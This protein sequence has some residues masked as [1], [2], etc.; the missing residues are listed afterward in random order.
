MG[1][2]LRHQAVGKLTT[3]TDEGQSLPGDTQTQNNIS[4]PTPSPNLNFTSAYS[5]DDPE[6][7]NPP[8]SKPNLQDPATNNQTNSQPTNPIPEPLAATNPMDTTPEAQ[9]KYRAQILT[10]IAGTTIPTLCDTGCQRSCISENFLRSHPA[11]YQC[12][13]KPYTGRTV[14]IDG[15]RV[16]TIGIINAEFRI[17]GRRLR[18]NL[19]IVR[20][21][22]FDFVLGWDFFTKYN[23][24]IH[25][26]KGYFTFEN[27]KVD[28]IPNT[29]QLSSTH[30]SLAEDAVIPPLSKMHTEA[31][32]YINPADNITTTDTVEVEP[33]RGNASRVAVAKTVSKV[34]DGRFMVELLNPYDT[35][36]KIEA[37]S[38][39][40]H[41]VFTSDE[42]LAGLAE[43]TGITFCFNGDESYKMTEKASAAADKPSGGPASTSYATPKKPPEAKPPDKASELTTSPSI[44]YSS[45]AEDAKPHLKDLKHLLEVKHG[46]IF[47]TNDRDR[48]CTDLVSH[49]ANI[50]PGP[51]IN[52]PPYRTTPEMQKEM[53]RQV[54]EM[55]ADGL[56]SHSTS[57]YSAPVLLV[58]KKLGGWRFCTD[59][60]KVNARCERMVYPLPRI[61]DALRRLKNPRYFSTMDLQKG[62]WQVPIE[63]SD[64]KYFAFST[65]TMHVEYNCMPMGALNS[66]ATMQALMSLILRG[67]PME[68]VICFLDDILVASSSMEEHIH[69]LDLVL[70]AITK[71]KLKLNPKKCL[72]A[73]ESVSCLGH[74]LS[75]DG[76]GPDPHNLDKIRKWKP[77][78]NVTE[79][80]SFL[81]LTGYYRQ[82]IKNYARVAAPLSDLTKDGVEWNWTDKAQ[83][84]FIHLRDYLTSNSI[85][86]YP[87]FSKPFW[88]KSDASGCSVGF[89]LTQFFDG[90]ERVIAYGSKKLT[91]TQKNYSTYDR[92][93][94]GILTAIRAYSH[95][96]RHS[97][98]KVVTDHRPL[99]NLRT[100]DPKTDATGRRVRWSIEL[101]LFDFEVIY[102]KGRQHS[103]ADAMS[104]ITDHDDYA[105]E[106]EYAGLVDNDAPEE[107]EYALL[108]A[109]DKDTSTAVDLVSDDAKRAL[110]AEAQNED[111]TI[112]E[113]KEILRNK[114]STAPSAVPFY[115]QNF[116]RLILK[117]GILYRRAITGSADLPILQAI[118]PPKLI[119]AVLRD[120]HGSIFAG[121]PGHQRFVSILQ[122]HVTWPG[123]YKDTKNFVLKCPE[124]DLVTE[125]N[126][127]P[128][129]EL[130]PMNPEYVFQ[131]VCCDLIALPPVP[132]GWKYVCVFMDVFSRHVMFYKLKNK[133][134]ESFARALEDYVTHVGCPQ[135][136]TC[137]NGSEF[138]SEL[139][140]AV[141]KVLGIKKK[142]SVV[143][144]PQSQGMVERM[145]RSI[146]AQLTK[147][148][149]QFGGYWPEHLHYVA[150]AHNAA[151]ASRTGESPNLV[152]FG[153]ELPLPTFTSNSV[154]TLRS[155]SVS[156]YVER[157]KQKVAVVQE[158]VKAEAIR[159]SE[160]TAEL[161]NKKVKHQPYKEGDYVYYKQIP[162]NRTKIDPRWLGPVCVT[163]RHTSATGTPG[164]TYT[165][166][167]KGG[168]TLRR[169]YE[170]LKAV[171]ADVT[172]P[173]AVEDLP[174]APAPRIPLVIIQHSEDEETADTQN[175]PVATRTRSRRAKAVSTANVAATPATPATSLHQAP[176]AIVST[177]QQLTPMT[178][179]S[180]PNPITRASTISNAP[181]PVVAP[182][183][184]TGPTPAPM[185]PTAPPTPSNT[186]TPASVAPM[187]LPA[188]VS[189]P[190]S[191]GVQI[192]VVSAPPQQPN[193]APPPRLSAGQDLNTTVYPR[194]PCSS[195][196]DTDGEVVNSSE[197]D[198]L[199]QNL[200]DD[201]SG[202]NSFFWE[203]DIEDPIL[204]PDAQEGPS[205]VPGRD[206]YALLHDRHPRSP[207][208]GG[209]T[210]EPLQETMVHAR[211]PIYTIVEE[212]EPPDSPPAIEAVEDRLNASDVASQAAEED[213][214]AVPM[215]AAADV[216]PI[217][218]APDILQIQLG[219][220]RTTQQQLNNANSDEPL[221][222]DGLG[223][224][225]V[226]AEDLL[227]IPV[228]QLTS[229]A[230]SSGSSSGSLN[231][232]KHFL[233]TVAEEMELRE[234]VGPKS[235]DVL[236]YKEYDLRLASRDDRNKARQTWIC[237]HTRKY[238]NCRGR[239]KLEVHDLVNITPGAIVIDYTPHNHKPK[240]MESHG[241]AAERT[242]PDT[243]TDLDG[244]ASFDNA[245]PSLHAISRL[246]ER[247]FEDDFADANIKAKRHSSPFTSME[248]PDDQEA[249]PS[250]VLRPPDVGEN[251][252]LDL[253]TVMVD[254]S[255]VD[256]WGYT[257]QRYVTRPRAAADIPG[258]P[259]TTLP[260]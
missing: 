206:Y 143:Y 214:M 232:F 134:T 119:Q 55:L 53:D 37:N 72:F 117:D 251:P 163:K 22:V 142:T 193:L 156:E 182:T 211:S 198:L 63:P 111:D 203:N 3:G 250:S 87:D 172:E 57:P 139:V 169:N 113:I 202:D 176:T 39:L 208:S 239:L 86:S 252:T 42:E 15:S 65:G 66:S 257:I 68:H 98:F 149:K 181:I 74:R 116:K 70:S 233:D 164:T 60:R 133:T 224:Q 229:T 71:A 217:H 184:T 123:I 154:N 230:G 155:K 94:F 56:V 10:Q 99:L 216:L 118:I 121:H 132:S 77:P 95:Y 226:P 50:K 153:R 46:K 109:D 162:K 31:T 7:T 188:V 106:E 76:I 30:F 97:H 196:H 85:M 33:L 179:S 104:R 218:S 144:R 146:I 244:T 52:I 148:L 73:Q 13:F 150:L 147:R 4:H 227:T 236:I 201:G 24:V 80:R 75:R 34:R 213:V 199:P 108:G 122:R 84:A 136:L 231:N 114:G 115:S 175:Q 173:I 82:M 49:H 102:K 19:R 79:I 141:V 8:D 17:K 41:V 35:P 255:Q 238:G 174:S 177:A 254:T 51:P 9:P 260:D 246:S 178:A 29:L 245:T 186:P 135:K 69:H 64:R 165:L 258:E 247:D 195:E 200:F 21:L 124:C 81:G 241:M 215:D 237:R 107:V 59:F 204:S 145:N 129:T 168:E 256:V 223:T 88:V 207:S 125:P 91:D 11:L 92:E 166:K 20:N 96:L 240:V 27:E 190:L 32:F 194:S 157:L 101:N 140:D 221:A 36:M 67:L 5:D 170:Q 137:D 126:P 192:C 131:H 228:A 242:L 249:G 259:P 158:A 161:Y 212:E 12:K 152:F 220:A 171:K 61:D 159:Q 138:C 189:S 219:D 78:T 234:R 191:S 151:P 183:P 83:A 112:R 235:I 1:E 23:C 16:E 120:A 28:L 26:G 58:K 253:T 43:P 130:Q 62:F 222:M 54:H 2:I 225:D 128:R 44:D 25:P 93:F 180:V 14:S 100:I 105:E 103:D 110:L 248:R 160:K 47:A 127:P 167:L 243:P 38:L 45:I 185:A 18:M 205:S 197:E 48:G 40:G 209:T 6:L 187:S 210:P 89:V 90:K